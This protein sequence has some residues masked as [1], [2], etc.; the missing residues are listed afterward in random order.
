M[1]AAVNQTFSDRVVWIT[2]ASSGIGAALARACASAGAHVIL[3]A[4]REPELRAVAASLAGGPG[5][6]VVL[7]LDLTLPATFATAVR[8][9]TDRFG[10]IDWLINNGGLGQRGV[11]A[12]TPLEIDRRI[13]EVNYFGQIGLTK[14]VLPDM[15]ARG[16]GRI[17]VISSVVG[18][19]ATPRRS[20]YAASKHALHGFFNAL[21][22]EVHAAGVRVTLV[23]PGYVRTAISVHALD[24]TGTAHAKLDAAQARAMTADTFAAR[25]LPRLAAGQNEI[26]LGGPER[27]AILLQRFCPAITARILR[28]RPFS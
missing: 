28:R 1:R 7:P 26:H 24:S 2:G 20:A 6:H 16:S 12:A 8:T 19:V 15:L 14:A 21:R 18:Y 17:V 3:S 13:M 11:A 4:R 23:C 25:L 22:A 5:R 9:V 27:F 10:R